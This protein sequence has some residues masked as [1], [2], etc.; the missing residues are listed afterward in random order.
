MSWAAQPGNGWGAETAP[1]P[2]PAGYLRSL[3]AR[4]RSGDPN[5]VYDH[6][7]QP[8]HIVASGGNS[9]DIY[10]S[11]VP[12]VQWVGFGLDPTPCGNAPVRLPS[13]TPLNAEPPF[14]RREIRHGVEVDW[15]DHKRPWLAYRPL[16]DD[17]SRGEWIY[18]DSKDGEYA[19]KVGGDRFQTNPSSMTRLVD[20]AARITKIGE[21][22]SRYLGYN[23]VP[24]RIPP[25]SSAPARKE[26]L[27]KAFATTRRSMIE[28]IAFVIYLV[29]H[30]GNGWESIPV[31]VA[32]WKDPV[33][34]WLS[35]ERVGTLID[36]HLP[37]VTWPNVQE[38]HL[39]G[40][41]PRY[42]WHFKLE[43]GNLVALDPRNLGAREIA[44]VV[45]D[46]DKRLR[47]WEKNKE[48][49]KER[50]NNL[51]RKDPITEISQVRRWYEQV[52]ADDPN[53]R[54][55][56]GKDRIKVGQYM[57]FAVRLNYPE[58]GDGTLFLDEMDPAP[59][60]GQ[61]AHMPKADGDSED[62]EEFISPIYGKGVGRMRAP[63]RSSPES[64]F[65]T[66][67]PVEDRPSPDKG[68][69]KAVMR[70]MDIDE[71][72]PQE[73]LDMAEET[74]LADESNLQRALQESL[75]SV[76]KRRGESSAVNN[77]HEVAAADRIESF[78]STKEDSSPSSVTVNTP[79]TMLVVSS[80]R[81]RAREEGSLESGSDNRSLLQR[82][83][84]P[85][86]V[87]VMDSASGVN[88]TETS[89]RPLL[90]RI[91]ISAGSSLNPP[92]LL[93]RMDSLPTT[94]LMDRITSGESTPTTTNET[95]PVGIATAPVVGEDELEEVLEEVYGQNYELAGLA[96]FTP[97]VLRPNGTSV[98][99]P[100]ID[101]ILTGR[102]H[103]LPR[104]M[105]RAALWRDKSSEPW[106][107]II[108]FFLRK[109]IPFTWSYPKALLQQPLPSV[110]AAWVSLVQDSDAPFQWWRSHADPWEAY[111][112]T[113]RELLVQPNARLFLHMGGLAWRL[114]K[115]FGP[116]SLMEDAARG[117]SRLVTD[118]GVGVPTRSPEAGIS[119]KERRV[120]LDRLFGVK[121]GRSLWP[122]Q[123]DFL[124]S[125]AWNGEWSWSNEVWFS[126][127]LAAL[128]SGRSVEPRT[129]SQWTKDL[130]N[131]LRPVDHRETY[132]AGSELHAQHMI[133]SDPDVAALGILDFV[134]LQ[135]AFE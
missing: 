2:T 114:A 78:N 19:L 112:T 40:A 45:R 76:P 130:R 100:L 1:A 95:S 51:L 123:K 20:F 32:G 104:S 27:Q 106:P 21:I 39:H 129:P 41:K 7:V 131:G 87:L 126:I 60:V 113:V 127:R 13:R 31:P 132:G 42:L 53:S 94:S 79:P 30:A 85:Q 111:L 64:S 65:R 67:P 62:E 81:K 43:G 15:W 44:V 34:G 102:V 10:T 115:E 84:G 5:A 116:A 91:S 124:D 86:K 14:Y 99:V 75:R 110:P 26:E 133:N 29:T 48:K 101:P 9:V 56:V 80:T 18:D 105:I 98:V 8:Y 125:R 119:D 83:Q 22:L 35:A 54:V 97:A 46:R 3:A 89:T 52:D 108:A 61:W 103:L 88:N 72:S 25:V 37:R 117:P 33:I 59:P 122:R 107:R 82:M 90:S 92:S 77:A 118:Y 134:V 38:L 17:Y 24:L 66:T 135:Q 69:G 71:P 49:L 68:K 16:P 70:P 50:T 6:S 63:E 23:V 121:S 4:R 128:V 28:W 96:T 36:F 58:P 12:G 120:D 47:K 55:V 57:G 109:G 11:S 93:T 73:L 74:R